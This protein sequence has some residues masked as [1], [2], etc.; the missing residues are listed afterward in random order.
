[1][2]RKLVAAPAAAVAVAAA[3]AAPASIPVATVY[4]G[5]HGLHNAEKA[6]GHESREATVVDYAGDI[7]LGMTGGS[8]L[9]LGLAIGFGTVGVVAGGTATLI[10][11][12]KMPRPQLPGLSR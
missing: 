1:M 8:A 5:F 2:V 12:Y 6:V 3:V 9:G 11:G 4:G 7:A 10:G